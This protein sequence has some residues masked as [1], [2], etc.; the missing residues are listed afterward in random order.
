MRQK[1]RHGHGG[2]DECERD[3]GGAEG[4]GAHQGREVEM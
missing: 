1:N 4:E 2:G 3:L